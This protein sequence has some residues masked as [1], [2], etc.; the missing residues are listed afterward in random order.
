M[1]KGDGRKGTQE[2]KHTIKKNFL[3]YSCMSDVVTIILKDRS[4][5]NVKI[6]I[7]LARIIELW[8]LGDTYGTKSYVCVREEV[9]KH[10]LR[11]RNALDQGSN[12]NGVWM[13]L[14]SPVST[15]QLHCHPP[16]EGFLHRT[17][18]FSR[19]CLKIETSSVCCNLNVSV[20]LQFTS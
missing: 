4:P 8:L 18:G 15:R 13:T 9:G 7:F 17:G 11:K 20:P 19:F 10:N 14:D 12:K 5:W 16:W 6:S 3:H 2:E 1:L